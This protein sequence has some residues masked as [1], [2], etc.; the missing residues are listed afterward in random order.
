MDDQ[1]VGSALR[2]VRMRRRF[3][4]SDLG[5]LAGVSRTTILRLERGHIGS[6]TVDTL[7]RVA[8]A[9]D[10]RIDL[11]A[12]WRAAD[13]DRL[14]NARHSALHEQVAGC[15]VTCQG[16]SPS[17]SVVMGSG[18]SWTSWSGIRSVGGCSSLS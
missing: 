10:V 11:T 15:F 14:L 12:R 13:L 18:A 16:G 4:Q 9:L 8:G 6:L 3:R 2:A 17:L 5:A 1:R 7:R